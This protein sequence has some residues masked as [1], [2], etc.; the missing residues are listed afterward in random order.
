[1]L[2]VWISIN[3]FNGKQ[4]TMVLHCKDIQFSFY[5][6]INLYNINKYLLIYFTFELKAYSYR[7]PIFLW[8]LFMLF[9][10]GE[11]LSFYFTAIKRDIFPLRLAFAS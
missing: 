7:S 1:M 10:I 3:S 2:Q 4:R 11:L 5:L 9:N 6:Y 8:A